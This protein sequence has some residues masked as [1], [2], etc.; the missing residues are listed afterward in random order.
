MAYA[1]IWTQKK[2]N[3]RG[4]ISTLNGDHLKLVDKFTY[5]VNSDSSTEKDINTWLAKT[6]TTIERLPVI[7]KSNLSEK[8]KTQF[9]PSSDRINTATWMHHVEA[10]KACEE[11]AWRQLYKNATS[12]IEQVL[13]V[14]PH[15][16]AVIR[17]PT[18]HHE[19]HPN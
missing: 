13:E 1:S 5:L 7:W 10:D 17:P 6:W 9:F 3:Q 12:C 18:T 11:K 15:K 4:N 2:Q 8:K 16:I 19:N 14:T